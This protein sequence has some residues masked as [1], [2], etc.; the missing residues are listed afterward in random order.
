MKISGIY[1]ISSISKSKRIYIGS[2][3]NINHRWNKG[4]KGLQVA[5]NKGLKGYKL[6]KVV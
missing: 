6:K 2:S 1:K 5:W 3:L 4:R